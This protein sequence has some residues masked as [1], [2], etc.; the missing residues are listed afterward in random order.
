MILRNAT[1]DDAQ[2]LLALMHQLGYTLSLDD[3]RKRIVAYNKDSHHVIV[4]EESGEVRG[5]IAFICYELFVAKGQCMHIE[6]MVVD[7]KH[8]RRGI[9]KMLLKEAEKIALESCCAI[10]ELIT[11]NSRRLRGTHAFYESMGYED[12]LKKDY[13]YFSKE[14]GVS[15]G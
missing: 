11:L 4:A 12:H 3:M 6:A 9:G 1:L 14:L 15:H 2:Q 8:Q 7:E 5:F 10:I 13:T